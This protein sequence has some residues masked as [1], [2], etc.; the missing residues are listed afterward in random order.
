MGKKAKGRTLSPPSSTPIGEEVSWFLASRALLPCTRSTYSVLCT[1]HN[2]GAA[3]FHCIQALKE[4]RTKGDRSFASGEF[5]KAIEAYSEAIKILPD[6]H[7]DKPL[8]FSNK[9]ACYI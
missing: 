9:A 2:I 1:F 7:G 3:R 6:S 8:F 4:L 5:D